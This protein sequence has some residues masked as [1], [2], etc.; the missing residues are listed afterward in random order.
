MLNKTISELEER[1]SKAD[2]IT[3]EE[4]TALLKLI[5]E[6]KVEITSLSKTH[7]EQ[8]KSI[9]GF[10]QVAAHEAMRSDKNAGLFKIAQEG[11]EKSVEDF[12]LTHPTLV[13]T[14]REISDVLSNLG[15]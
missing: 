13:E 3:G 6:L 9:A 2:S 11:L 10:T 4:R 12:E 15:I 8:A 5:G 7:E 14:I 1:I